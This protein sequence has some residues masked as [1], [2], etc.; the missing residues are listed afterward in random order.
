MGLFDVLK[1]GLNSNNDN[2]SN[3]KITFKEEITSDDIPSLQERINNAFPSENGLYPHEIL[4]LE[5]ASSFKNRDNSFQ[6]FWKWNYSV[7]DP[8][9][10]LESLYER[11]FICYGDV[12][13]V[14]NKTKVAELKEMLSSKGEKATGKKEAL[15]NKVL[16]IY[17]ECELEKIFPERYFEL[18]E[19][20]KT[21]VE[22]NKYVLFAHRKDYISA[23]ELNVLMQDRAFEMSYRDV[24]WGEFNRRSLEYTK[25]MHFGLYRNCRLNMH[26]FLVEEG[27]YLDALEMLVEVVI[28][29]L[30]GLGNNE[31]DLMNSNIPKEKKVEFKLVNLFKDDDEKEVIVLP[32]LVEYAERLKTEL[33]LTDNEFIKTVYSMANKVHMGIGV[34]NADECAN[35]LLYLMGLEDRKIKNSY[36]EAIKRLNLMVK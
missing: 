25:D 4:M 29:D 27:R 11:G 16:A 7:L 19:L 14:L 15:I 1:K 6:S 36:K 12:I 33:K 13:S 23:W 9:Q 3:T 28:C 18:T 21:E 35:T 34:F 26:D 31:K 17:E 8:Q 32:R 10:L 30:S 20:G 22:N 24:M 2:S 5:Y